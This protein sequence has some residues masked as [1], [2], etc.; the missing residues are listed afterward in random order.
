[1]NAR[2]VFQHGTPD[3][4]T[5]AC[6]FSKTTRLSGNQWT[7]APQCRDK[8]YP[9]P[10][11]FLKP[12]INFPLAIWQGNQLIKKAGEVIGIA[13]ISESWYWSVGVR[14]S[15]L[16]V[17]V[18]ILVFRLNDNIPHWQQQRICVFDFSC[19]KVLKYNQSVLH[20][21]RHA[22]QILDWNFLQKKMK[23]CFF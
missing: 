19:K 6:S 11:W 14:S 16:L 10:K 22:R 18:S 23:H 4:L 9:S 7:H 17:T 3:T 12:L 21:M 8:V 15:E 1:M 20:F 2:G 5:P 13:L